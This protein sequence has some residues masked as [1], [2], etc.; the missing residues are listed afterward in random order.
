MQSYLAALKNYANFSGSTGLSQFWTFVLVNFAIG[1]VLSALLPAVGM[2]YSLA[3]LVPS[4]AATVRRLNDTAQ[5]PWYI[6]LALI[7]VVGAVMLIFMCAQPTAATSTKASGFANM[8]TNPDSALS[9]SAFTQDNVSVSS[10]SQNKS[11]T[12]DKQPTN[13]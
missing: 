13:S 7:P 9:G 2:V 1:A 5:S 8:D 6:L 4:V 3:V 12:K 10:K 11:A